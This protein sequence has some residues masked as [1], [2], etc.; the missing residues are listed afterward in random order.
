MR[1]IIF[2][3]IVAAMFA[4][5]GVKY[6]YRRYSNVIDF[7][8]V[9]QAGFF[10]T[11]SNSVSFQYD[12]L[13]SVTSVVESGYEVLGNKDGQMNDDVYSYKSSNTKFGKYTYA[14][15]EDAI[16]ELISSAQKLGANGIINLKITY[17][18]SVHDKYG[19]IISPSSYVVSG[20]AIKRK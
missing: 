20:M 18:P 14:Q 15:A 3:I 16:S 17:T 19:N 9:T 5:C 10:I 8:E 12:P 13:G 2:F 7:T 4:S 1:K 6:P 11:E